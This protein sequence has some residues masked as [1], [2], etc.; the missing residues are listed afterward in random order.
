MKKIDSTESF[1]ERIEQM[2]KKILPPKEDE[3]TTIKNPR[4]EQYQRQQEEFKERQKEVTRKI[5]TG[6]YLPNEE[7]LSEIHKRLDI[8]S[9]VDPMDYALGKVDEYG[10]K[11]KRPQ[12]QQQSSAV[13]NTKSDVDQQLKDLHDQEAATKK[14]KEEQ[15]ESF[16]KQQPSKKKSYPKKKKQQP[17]Q[18]KPI[19]QHKDDVFGD[20]SYTKKLKIDEQ[21]NKNI[22]KYGSNVPDSELPRRQDIFAEDYQAHIPQTEEEYYERYN[23]EHRMTNKKQNTPKHI[24]SGRQKKVYSGKPTTEE[25]KYVEKV[26]KKK[27]VNIKPKENEAE[28]LQVNDQGLYV[29]PTYYNDLSELENIQ[30]DLNQVQ[31]VTDEN[32]NLDQIASKNIDYIINNRPTTE[33]IL[34]QSGYVAFMSSL[35]L[36][37]S[38]TLLTSVEDDYTSRKNQYNLLYE[39]IQ[40]TNIG[41]LTFDEFLN[42]TSFNDLESL[43]YGLFSS[44]YPEGTEYT[45]KCQNEDCKKDIDNIKVTNQDIIIIKDEDSLEQRRTLIR[46]INDP[47]AIKRYSVLNKTKQLVLPKSKYI[48]EIEVPSLKKDL[49]IYYA[50]KQ[51]PNNKLSL[52]FLQFVKSVSVIDLPTYHKTKQIKYIR[53]NTFNNLYN[54]LSNLNVEDTRVLAEVIEQFVFQYDVQYGIAKVE[55]PFCHHIN[56]DISID[57]QKLTFEQT[58]QQV[59]K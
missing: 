13:R 11:I 1:D 28:T 25:K 42:I 55:C 23:K 32:V 43:Y 53:S 49:T 47:E 30:I 16:K 12:K 37:D 35:S 31:Y 40:S 7:E 6:D 3:G 44:T 10:E 29:E 52:T 50:M 21:V 8:M 33:V 26:A 46:N 15:V 22:R 20:T 38:L 18:K 2:N 4:Y 51:K 27:K 19:Q 56:K 48:I 58:F 9:P 45:I 34:N 14:E 5:A 57:V 39:K 41:K 24:K 17:S 54:L 36:N 59:T